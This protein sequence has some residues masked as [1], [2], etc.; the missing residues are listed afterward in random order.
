MWYENDAKKPALD[1]SKPI[2]AFYRDTSTPA[3]L[4]LPCM[5]TRSDKCEYG[6]IGYNWFMID[7]GSWNSV[8]TWKSPEEAVDS[9]DDTYDI[10]NVDLVGVLS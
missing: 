2:V 6:I 1:Y 7:S 10:R 5:E 4:L 8:A 9:Y 3:H